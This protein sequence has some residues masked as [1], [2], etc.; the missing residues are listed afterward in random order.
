MD[1]TAQ[2]VTRIDRHLKRTGQTAT[3]FG[4][5]ALNNSALVSRIRAG[6]VTAKTMRTVSDY[7]AKHSNRFAKRKAPK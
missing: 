6:N 5:E 7:L 1:P 2:L 4:I 3:A